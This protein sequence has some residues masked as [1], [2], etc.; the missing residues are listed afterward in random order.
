MLQGRWGIFFRIFRLIIGEF[1]RT[2]AKAVGRR[3][4]TE[5]DM[6][7]R[8]IVSYEA[9]AD[10]ALHSTLSI[11]VPKRYWDKEP[12][13]LVDWFVE[14][15]NGK[16]PN[17]TLSPDAL[18][19]T[20]PEGNAYPLD[21]K[22]QECFSH[23]QEV[24]LVPLA[25]VAS[26]EKAGGVQAAA[27]AEEAPAA[28]AP[29][30]G[31]G[32]L[33]IVVS[34]PGST[35]AKGKDEKNSDAKSTDAKSTGSAEKTT[36]PDVTSPSS[37]AQQGI[38]WRASL[39]S[40]ITLNK[41]IDMENP[42]EFAK[43]DQQTEAQFKTLKA[44]HGY[45]SELTLKAAFKLL[46][47][48]IGQYKLDRV[49]QVLAEI[50]PTCRELAF[51]KKWWP[52][53]VQMQAFCRWKQ[54][55]FKEALVLFEE[56]KEIVGESS[57][58]LENMGHTHSSLGD[59][60]KARECF[61]KALKLVDIE[62]ALRPGEKK[63]KGGLFMGLGL[64]KKRQ[65][66][67]REGLVDLRKSLEWYEQNTGPRPHSLCAKALMSIGHAHEELKEWKLAAQH[68]SRAVDLFQR[69]C[70]D[71][72]PLTGNALGSLGKVYVELEQHEQAWNALKEAFKNEVRHD[73]L[74]VF[75]LFDH[76]TLL[77][78]LCTTAKAKGANPKELVHALR[79][80]DAKL[81]PQMRAGLIKRDGNIGALYKSMAELSIVSHQYRM[82]RSFLDKALRFFGEEKDFDCGSLIEECRNILML[83]ID[84]IRKGIGS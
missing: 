27:A 35:D 55:K 50:E 29:A 79:T 45:A 11:R 19:L 71:N 13:H 18:K 17:N 4:G 31:G 33:S 80:L 52:R 54:S 47:I 57:K 43:A 30:S 15:Y 69:T 67:V 73:S 42:E 78:R 62:A 53:H 49:D 63:N 20:D 70:G 3:L 51:R 10:K 76:A 7:L 65:G 22:M 21:G 16:F 84:L 81:E 9:C 36:N 61:E 25:G 74:K 2:S 56:M 68:M 64:V 41:D 46:D 6:P 37:A 23:K 58:L 5:E 75:T 66:K 38:G 44:N 28:A 39:G 12:R 77:Y 24:C 82:A 72:S 1:A 34:G 8:V 59:Y 40:A 26:S 83:V 14:F 60:P 32:G 48:C